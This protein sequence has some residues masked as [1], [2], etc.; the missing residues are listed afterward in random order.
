MQLFHLARIAIDQPSKNQNPRE[1]I[2]MLM[3][4]DNVLIMSL[5]LQKTKIP[6]RGLKSQPLNEIA[7]TSPSSLL[8]KTKIPARGLKFVGYSGFVP[9]AAGI[10]SKNQN[11]REG[12]EIVNN[13]DVAAVATD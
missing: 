6:A 12:I 10:T 11:P 2:E 3:L 1:G 13:L 5:C 9:F 7:R 4:S 8:Q